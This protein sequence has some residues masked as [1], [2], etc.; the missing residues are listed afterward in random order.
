MARIIDANLNR[1]REALRVLEEHARF[2]LD[3]ERLTRRLKQ[4][5]HDLAAA[6]ATFDTAALLEARD[7]PGD[8]GTTV[9]TSGEMR[10]DD[11]ASVV[12]AAAKRL[13]ESLRA[14]EEYAKIDHPAAAAAFE[15]L[16]YESYA[17]E[18]AL[19]THAPRAARLRRGLVHVLVTEAL[20]RG[21]WLDVTEAALRG[22]A[23]V[24]Q[25]REKT[26]PD[27]ELLAR[28]RRLRDLTARFDALLIVNDRADIARLAEA[29][30]V[31]V[32]QNDLCVAE[33]RQIAGPGRL[34]GRSTHSID[35]ATS[36]WHERPDY[37]G[38]GPMFISGTKAALRPA[39][40]RLLR[41]V[42][43]A[44]ASRA[45]PHGGPP[46]LVAIG[47]IDAGNAG[48]IASCAPNAAAGGPQRNAAVPI[49]QIAACQ[50]VIASG[51]AERAV[52]ELRSRLQRVEPR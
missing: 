1:A 52:R 42:A 26:L 29:D 4:A 37:I 20:C 14:L 25:L 19:F 38:V 30:G 13:A 48:E 33:I 12:R 23:D 7:T 43:A 51:D 8:V 44:M 16:R 47:G 46:V 41:E 6:S 34:A 3:D 24:I 28:A 15:R 50:S 27:G 36:A 49:V 39:G 31:H 2:A 9:S 10:R 21:P 40:P 32:G 5:R 35:E 11:A 17:V 45:E 18:Q 22:G